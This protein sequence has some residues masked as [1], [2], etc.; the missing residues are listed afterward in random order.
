MKIHI[1]PLAATAILAIVSVPTAVQATADLPDPVD[2]S[3]GS[4]KA[5]V[6]ATWN[7]G[8][9][10]TFGITC[11]VIELEESGTPDAFQKAIKNSMKANQ[12]QGM[13][14]DHNKFLFAI[15]SKFKYRKYVLQSVTIRISLA[16]ANKEVVAVAQT[17]ASTTTGP[18]KKSNSKK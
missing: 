3:S 5:D 2:V 8:A 7:L 6:C 12:S 9:D 10:Y 13:V 15:R 14:F 1:L 16:L 11:A 17:V 18:K 4:L